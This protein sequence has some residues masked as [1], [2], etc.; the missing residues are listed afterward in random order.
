MTIFHEKKQNSLCKN[1]CKNLTWNLIEHRVD[2]DNAYF[3]EF[4]DELI[5]YLK[6][7]CENFDKVDN[8]YSEFFD[9]KFFLKFNY[10]KTKTKFSKNTWNDLTI[11]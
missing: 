9:D 7:L 5:N 10:S 6:N 11:W 1:F 8:V 4:N 3:Y 2:Y